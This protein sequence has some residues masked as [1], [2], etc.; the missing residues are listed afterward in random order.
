MKRLIQQILI[1]AVANLFFTTP[2]LTQSIEPEAVPGENDDFLVLL[3]GLPATTNIDELDLSFTKGVTSQKP[4][5]DSYW[6]VYKGVIASRYKMQSQPTSSRWQ[7]Y[8]NHYERNPAEGLIA[9]GQIDK[10]SPA[11]KYDLLIGDRNWSLTKTM[12]K[13]GQD[14]MRTHGVV[15]TWTGICHGWSAAN[16]VGIPRPENTIILTDVTGRHE[17]PFTAFD[18]MAYVSYYWSKPP[19]ESFFVGNRCK[20]AIKRT[21]EGRISDPKCFDNNPMTWHLGVTNRVG[22][23]KKSIIMD[24][25]SNTEVWNYVVDNYQYSYFNPQTLEFS[26]QLQ[27]AIAVRE[28]F[29]QDPFHNFRSDRTKFLVG[30]I[31]DV[32][33]P[34]AISPHDGIPSYRRLEYKRF[35][36]DLELDENMNVVGG[37]WHTKEHPDFMWGYPDGNNRFDDPNYIHTILPDERLTPASVSMIDPALATS[38]LEA[39][40]KGRILSELL[41]KLIA[42]SLRKGELAE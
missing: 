16:N 24:T 29:R 27:D 34:G 26:S 21:P 14:A 10:L 6:P 41:D 30:V 17:I 40:Q 42:L 19:V 36:Y 22:K 11:E 9:A 5:S 28:E 39:S 3:E 1:V 37:E 15:A 33:H 12:W 18:L 23:I 7:D 32:F 4:W 38:A 2:T 25:S 13:R 8:Y 20:T 35:I 31:M